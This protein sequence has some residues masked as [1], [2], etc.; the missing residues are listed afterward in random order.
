MYVVNELDSTVTSYAFDSSSGQLSPIETAQSV[1]ATFLGANRAAALVASAKGDFIFASNR[2]HDSLV[3]F[4]VDGT[5]GRLSDA[6][7]QVTLGQG[8][9]FAVVSPTGRSLFVANE[10]SDSVV[11]YG[12][13][14]TGLTTGPFATVE[15]GSPVSIVLI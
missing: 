2:G 4:S 3:Q 13:D 11:A 1:P 10:L 9:R 12:L 8:P 7:W 15:S 14:K 6:R 5:T